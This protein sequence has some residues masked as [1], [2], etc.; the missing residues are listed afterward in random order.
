MNAVQ[1]DS[2]R[3]SVKMFKFV[4]LS[5]FLVAARVIAQDAEDYET[6]VGLDD[7]TQVGVGHDI[8]CTKYYFCSGEVGI[9]EDC[10]EI[11]NDPDLAFNEETGQCEYDVACGD[12]GVDPGPEPEPE[13]NPPPVVVTTTQQPAVVPTTPSNPGNIPDVECP[14]NRPGEILFYP[15]SNCSQYFI[16]A[17][18][19]RLQMSCIDGFAWNEDD[20]Q[21]DHPIFSRC[22]SRQVS[23]I[24]K[25]SPHENNL[26]FFL[27]RHRG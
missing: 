27:E 19:V 23:S 12:V 2:P 24:T 22:A 6:C 13:T 14:T 5:V 20:N 17:S 15:S 10:T 1:F 16:C 8:S 7:E 4:I 21:C 18:G 3:T 25:I 26:H 11:Y 9:L